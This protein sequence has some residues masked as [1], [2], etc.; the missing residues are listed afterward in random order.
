MAYIC[1]HWP[2]L[3]EI[4]RHRLT[5]ADIYLHRHKCTKLWP[6]S[7][8]IGRH[9]RAS[10]DIARHRPTLANLGSLPQPFPMD[11]FLLGRYRPMLADIGRHRQIC[12]S[13]ADNSQC[14]PSGLL[15][16][17]GRQFLM[18]AVHSR[19][20]PTFADIGRPWQPLTDIGRRWPTST[21]IGRKAISIGQYRPTLADIGGCQPISADIGR[22][23]P[24]CAPICPLPISTN[25]VRRRPTS[26]DLVLLGRQWPM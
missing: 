4:D 20:G 18:S 3:A 7:A 2:T 21:F 14:C 5:L 10:T 13:Q 8:D 25:V 24:I 9:W 23:W 26:A 15:A 11:P 16:A 12:F 1:R 17:P 6:L 19:A 22:H